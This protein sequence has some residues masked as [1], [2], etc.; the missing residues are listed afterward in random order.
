MT[1]GVSQDFHSGRHYPPGWKPGSTAV[2][3][4]CRHGGSVKMRPLRNRCFD[5]THP[6]TAPACQGRRNRSSRKVAMTAKQK[7]YGFKIYDLRGAVE[8]Q[9]VRKVLADGHRPDP[10]AARLP[11]R[12]ANVPMSCLTAIVWCRIGNRETQNLRIQLAGSRLLYEIGS[13]SIIIWFRLRR[14]RF[15]APDF[16]FNF[17]TSRPLSTR[18]VSWIRTSETFSNI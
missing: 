6:S 2:K 4:A 13:D 10:P 3:D 18:V 15:C 17:S 12:P 7:N 8:N 11:S 1:S 16:Q 14:V 5:R 9:T